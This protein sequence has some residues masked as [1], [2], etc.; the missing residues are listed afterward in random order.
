MHAVIGKEMIQIF[1]DDGA[2]R[3]D[4]IIMHQRRHHRLRIYLH[5]AG[6]KLLAFQD[7]DIK[8]FPWDILFRHR[9]AH[10]GR[11]DWKSRDDR[12]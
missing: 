6:L 12:V 3:D 9:K 11:A 7:I 4:Q 2:V 5:K 1:N 10:L 8:P